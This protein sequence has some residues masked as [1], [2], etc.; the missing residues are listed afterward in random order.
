MVSPALAKIREQARLQMAEAEAKTKEAQAL[1]DA[2]DKEQRT[3]TKQER[4]KVS[5]LHS[6]AEAI[7]KRV[8]DELTSQEVAIGKAEIYGGRSSGISYG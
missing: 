2:A 3:L 7:K 5:K 1:I 8:K 4:D 6:E